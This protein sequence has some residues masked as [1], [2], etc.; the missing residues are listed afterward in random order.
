VKVVKYG[1]STNGQIMCPPHVERR[2][3]RRATEG[4]TRYAAGRRDVFVMTMP[5][6]ESQQKFIVRVRTG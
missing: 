4:L 2:G 6:W 3:R 5:A 1:S